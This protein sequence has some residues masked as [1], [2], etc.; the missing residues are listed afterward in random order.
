MKLE[1]VDRE[2]DGTLQWCKDILLKMTVYML[3]L[4]LKMT[5]LLQYMYVHS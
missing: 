1:T 5:M 2:W 3:F 4:L